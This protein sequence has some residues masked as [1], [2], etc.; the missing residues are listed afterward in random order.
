MS[1]IALDDTG[2][3]VSSLRKIDNLRQHWSCPNCNKDMV[4]V[5]AM[6]RIKHFR[7]YTQCEYETEPETERHLAM[8][9]LIH[10]IY[11]DSVLE[12]R[13]GN[14]INDCTIASEKVAVEVQCS[15]IST[16]EMMERVM[17]YN[18]LGYKVFWILGQ[19]T[20]YEIEHHLRLRNDWRIHSSEEWLQSKTVRYD[21][22]WWMFYEGKFRRG[23]FDF[24]YGRQCTGLMSLCY[25]QLI[26][27]TSRNVPFIAE[28]AELFGEPLAS[29]YVSE[30]SSSSPEKVSETKEL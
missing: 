24:N 21:G 7:H 12:N 22:G 19:R 2:M 9:S 28:G 3:R 4:Y 29:F 6:T 5:D 11:P 18:H 16:T 14:R 30:I 26:D 25:K 23:R 15:S 8:K 1:L 13:I 17:D 27:G 20:E 10:Q